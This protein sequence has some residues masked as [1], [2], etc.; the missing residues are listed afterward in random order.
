M[1]LSE[2]VAVA[3]ETPLAEAGGIVTHLIQ[4]LLGQAQTRLA[5]GMAEVLMVEAHLIVGNSFPLY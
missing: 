5:A 4:D 1:P 3:T 2:V